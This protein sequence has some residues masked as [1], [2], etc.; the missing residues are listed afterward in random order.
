MCVI[1]ADDRRGL[2]NMRGSSTYSIARSAGSADACAIGGCLWVL[3]DCEWLLGLPDRSQRHKHHNL[4]HI[5]TYHVLNTFST[6]LIIF[7]RDWRSASRLNLMSMCVCVRADAH[8]K[9]KTIIL[10]QCVTHILCTRSSALLSAH[11]SRTIVHDKCYKVVAAHAS[12]I[13]VC[14][15]VCVCG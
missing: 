8:K 13:G 14:V 4:N 1:I 6:Q 11:F 12:L 5:Q 10:S 3:C 7:I 9:Y 15:C 2:P